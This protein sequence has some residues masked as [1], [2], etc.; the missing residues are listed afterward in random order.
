MIRF[1]EKIMLHAGRR[2]DSTIIGPQM[3]GLELSFS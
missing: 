2:P 1:A 3:V